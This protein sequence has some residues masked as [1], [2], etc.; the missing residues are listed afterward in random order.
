MGVITH[1]MNLYAGV[2]ILFVSLVVCLPVSYIRLFIYLWFVC[3]LVYIVICLFIVYV[4]FQ[5]LFILIE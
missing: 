3:L 5:L 2:F 4:V 1:F